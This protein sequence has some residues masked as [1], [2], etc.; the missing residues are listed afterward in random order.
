MSVSGPS[1]AAINDLLAGQELRSG[2]L[3]VGPLGED[4]VRLLRTIW[5]IRDELSKGKGADQVN[6]LRR[7]YRKDT[8][9]PPA[10]ASDKSKAAP[11]GPLPATKH[12]WR[13]HKLNCQSIRGLAPAGTP[14]E[15]FYDGVSLLIYGPN[16]SGKTSLLNAVAWVLTGRV[17]TDADE[18]R[19][20]RTAGPPSCA[21]GRSSTPSRPATPTS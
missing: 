2:K 18:R 17:S 15:F 6:T 13:L 20:R 7:A 8:A 21:T 9:T 14:F 11:R 16:G 1:E 10:D 4:A 19:P 5:T 3:V 12:C